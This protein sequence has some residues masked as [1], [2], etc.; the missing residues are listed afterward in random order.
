ML[1]TIAASPTIGHAVP[2]DERSR[3]QA[4]IE[5][6][7]LWLLGLSGAVVIVEPSPY[8]AMFLL[9]LPLFLIGGMRLHLSS[10]ALIVPLVGFNIG[11][12]LSVL[13]FFQESRSVFFVVTSIYL[14]FTSVFFAC[15]MLERPVPRLNALLR[16]YV[17][18]AVIASFAGLL[19]YFDVA[20]LGDVFTL[21]GRASGTFKD[22]NV[23][24]VFVI[25]PL[26]FLAQDLLL[27]RR[28]FLLSA[29]QFGVILFGG[30]FLSF[31]RGAWAHAAVS[32]LLMVTL[33]F[34]LTP[35]LNLRRRIT[36]IAALGGI[37]LIGAVAVA[38]SLEGVREMLET[39]AS[40]DQ[41]YDLGETG[42][43]GN[44]L[45]SISEL[46]ERPNGFGPLRFRFHFP[47]DPH[48]VYVNAFASY[49][50]TGGIS[51][52]VLILLTVVIGWRTVLARLP[53]QP[54][55][56]AIWSV[57][58]V[59]ILQG[60]QIDTDHWRHWYLMLGL[61]WG[62]FALE[63]RQRRSA[64]ARRRVEAAALLPALTSAAPSA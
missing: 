3:V 29:L 55:A 1:S 41:S 13:P 40:L 51:Y 32:L 18:A 24:S 14:A 42:R 34:V 6:G 11:G 50:W 43:F 19:G 21:Y 15:L 60:F 52:I 45:R 44:Q 64:P 8:D 47:E 63:W 36:V 12:L 17:W 23:L 61:I 59:Q 27:R 38:A 5:N 16:G 37:V 25:L 57:L 31:S 10:L 62:L 33:T 22:P 49:G 58:F 46:L 48:N 54:Y 4:R 56:I 2:A 35:S 7:L 28:N 53:V 9:I 30:V 39:R 26:V 20:G